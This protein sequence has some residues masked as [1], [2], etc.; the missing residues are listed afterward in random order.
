MLLNKKILLLLISLNISNIAFAN[1]EITKEWAFYHP[2]A[3]QIIQ[4]L[5]HEEDRAKNDFERGT[6]T[7][8]Q[9]EK[10]IQNIKEI[11][12]KLNNF[13]SDNEGKDISNEQNVYLNGQCNLVYNRTISYIND[14]Q[15]E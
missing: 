4:R 7:K 5:N 12:D 2:L 13:V 9:A 8:G 6:I 15:E 11:T 1:I 10:I 3:T 14:N